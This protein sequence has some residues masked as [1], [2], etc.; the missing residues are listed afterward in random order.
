MSFD[1][2]SSR[3]TPESYGSDQNNCAVGADTL[4]SRDHEDLSDHKKPRDRKCR[5][6]K[7]HKPGPGDKH[8][9]F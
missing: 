3:G 9:E 7:K 8:K 4:G 6:S 5:R 2:C 1:E